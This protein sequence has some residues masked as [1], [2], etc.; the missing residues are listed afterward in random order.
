VLQL[1]TWYSSC[2][3][4]L[5]TKDVIVK[6]CIDQF[7]T[8]SSRPSTISS[9]RSRVTEL[10]VVLPYHNN[11]LFD[12]CDIGLIKIERKISVSQHCSPTHHHPRPILHE[13]CSSDL[14]PL[15]I[16]FCA[17]IGSVACHT[18]RGRYVHIL[19]CTVPLS[20]VYN[21][22]SVVWRTERVVC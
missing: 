2:S 20:R 17:S 10:C 22:Y 7:A 11:T 19:M 8:C 18:F 6:F 3:E 4:K 21:V 1:V 15:N 13:Y 14:Y 9:Q 16:S 12:S 5:K